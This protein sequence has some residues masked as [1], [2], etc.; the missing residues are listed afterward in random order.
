MNTFQ[1]FCSAAISSERTIAGSVGVLIL[2]LLRGKAYNLYT[3]I[4]GGQL[5]KLMHIAKEC[6]LQPHGVVPR[7]CLSL[8]DV[9]R[10]WRRP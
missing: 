3:C 9:R 5:R 7:E 10:A 4:E 2:C 1:E 6:A 8:A